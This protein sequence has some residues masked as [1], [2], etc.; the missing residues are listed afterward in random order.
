[1]N[2]P[3]HSPA[4][5]N[6]REYGPEVDV[7]RAVYVDPSA[8]LYGRIRAGE[9]VSIWP[10]AVIRAEATQVVIGDYANVQDFVMIH[11]DY[12]HDVHIGKYVSLAHHCIVHGAHIEDN[13]LVGINATIMDRVVIGE[14]SLIGAGAVVTTETVIPPY[15]IVVGAPA[16]VVKTRNSWLDN[17]LNALL[18]YRNGQ[19]YTRGDHRAWEGKEYDEWLRRERQRLH[20][21]F[22]ARWE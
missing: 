18:Y 8:N 2:R 16:K 11:I 7:A 10:N 21:E 22:K 6:R 4:Q 1:M 20:E 14:N 9:G 15:S 13:V 3:S 12:E 19:A 5:E 17:R